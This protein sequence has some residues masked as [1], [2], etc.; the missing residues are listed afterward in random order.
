MKIHF[1]GTGASEGVPALFCECEHCKKIRNTGGKN[2]RTR[3]SAQI[4]D[5]ILID[6]S[7][8]SYAQ[9]LF[10]GM[11][12]SKINHLLITHSHEDHFNPTELMRIKPPM[13]F[14]NR[15]RMLNIYGNSTVIYKLRESEK[16]YDVRK[17]DVKDYITDYEISPFQKFSMGEYQVTA[18]PANH[19]KREACFIYVLEHGDKTMLYGH[20]TAMFCEETWDALAQFRFNCVVLDCTMV[21]ER[22]VLTGHMGFPEN[23]EI[24]ERMVKEEMAD[25]DT[26]FIATHFAHTFNPLPARIEPIFEKQGFLAAYDGMEVN[27]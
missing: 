4:D 16:L 6:F 18:L 11:D 15:K 17:A 21:E 27:F 13:A 20:D 14:Y 10:R 2:Y 5:E 9:V 3:T 26:V 1:Y 25:E 22:G 23:V 8:D 19:D 12:L 24:R 7:M